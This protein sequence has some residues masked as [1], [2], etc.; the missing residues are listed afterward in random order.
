MAQADNIYDSVIK[1]IL[2]NGIWDKDQE[3]RTKWADGTPAYTKS[4]ISTQ[5]KF[6]NKE[7]PILTKKKVAW[8]TAIRELLWIWQMQSNDVRILREMGVNIWNEWELP[9]GTIGKSYGY[10]LGKRIKTKR[11]AQ[12]VDG[13][14]DV[15]SKPHYIRSTQVDEL[16]LGLKTDPSSRRH[17]TSLWNIDDLSEMSLNPCVW[18]TQSLVKDGYLHLIVGVRSN[19][20]GLGNAFNTFQYHVLQRMLAQV[21]G[22]KLGTLTFNIND[23]HIYERHEDLLKEQLSLP[24]YPAPTLWINPDITDFYDFTIDDFDLIDYQS[25]PAIKMEVA[26]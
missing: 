20:M 12:Y 14:I 26:I 21:T 15:M 7:T 17:V 11:K 2:D 6:D 23:A 19:D 1:D 10:Q 25:G 9:D 3:V 4:I 16:L 24:E 5:M 18:N 8:K 13:S 22:H